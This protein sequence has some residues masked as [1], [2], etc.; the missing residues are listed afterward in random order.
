MNLPTESINAK[1]NV[2][3]Y[4]GFTF[5]HG[6][7]LYPLLFI[8][9]AVALGFMGCYDIYIFIIRAVGKSTCRYYYCF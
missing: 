7:Y 6:N 5:V 8:L 4:L 9:M 2:L 3:N 1:K